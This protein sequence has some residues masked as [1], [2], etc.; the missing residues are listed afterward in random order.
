MS[1]RRLGRGLDSLLGDDYEEAPEAAET[2]VQWVPVDMIR[3]GTYQPRKQMNDDA[4]RELAE[5]IRSQGIVQ[6]LVVRRREE[7]GEYELIAGERRWR[8]A[9]LA[10]F[11][12]VPAMI[13]TLAD[14]QALE[15]ALI[16]NIQRE[17]LNPMEEARAFDRLVSEFDMTHEAI[18][19]RVGRNRA[20]ISNT[21]RLLRLPDPVHRALEEGTLR[22][23]HARALLALE[24]HERLG[25][26]AQEVVQKGMSVRATEDRVRKTLQEAESGEGQE[27]K[28]GGAVRKDPDIERLEQ[29]LGERLATRV[30]ITQR[31]NR[32][33]L[34]IEYTSVDELE[35]IVAR[36]R[37]EPGD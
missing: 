35:D 22:M 6:P 24:G 5:S 37:P 12:S 17:E 20:T 7:G 10:G 15:I 26:V 2:E 30:R 14:E 4:L 21:L 27:A 8:A 13:R 1:K 32:G 36:I 31:K 23:G 16:E 33:K 9:Q 11:E 18:A 25:E 3:P 29:D 19:E 28:P 34:E